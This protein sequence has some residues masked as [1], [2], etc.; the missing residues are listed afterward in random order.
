[1]QEG[2]FEER[3]KMAVQLGQAM[4]EGEHVVGLQKSYQKLLADCTACA[5]GLNLGSGWVFSLHN[6]K[7]LSTSKHGKY[8]GGT[9]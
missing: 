1:M 5:I 6:R 4:K 7:A 9:Y 8:P 3:S 2:L